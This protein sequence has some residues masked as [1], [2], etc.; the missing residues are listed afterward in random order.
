[1]TGRRFVGRV[2]GPLALALLC[3]VRVAAFP[4]SVRWGYANCATCHYNVAG[5][6]ILTPY[7]RQL[8]RELLST[9]G[10]EQTAPFAFGRV[11]TPEWLAIGG[12][13]CGY[14]ASG[15]KESSSS[16]HVM[17]AEL[18]AAVIRGRL[19]FVGTAGL[20]PSDQ[21]I[22]HGWTSSRHFAQLSLTPALSVR[23]GRFLPNY[24]IWNG[25]VSVAT[26]AGLGWD[27][28]HGSDNLELNLV[29]ERYNLGATLILGQRDRE[30]RERASGVAFTSGLFFA[31]KRK[32][33][34][35]LMATRSDVVDRQAFGLHGVIG[36]GRH[37]Y[38]LSETDLLRLHPR[39]APAEARWD[40]YGNWCLAYETIK[41]LYVLLL[42]ELARRDLA[43]EDRPSHSYGI[44]LRWFPTS[45]FE[46][47]LRLRK[48][49]E[50]AESP[51]HLN[52]LSALFRFYP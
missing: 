24:G 42:D 4:G 9:W 23:A 37:A 45:H 31:D 39:D 30:G 26:R 34:F 48:Q 5:G 21:S 27:E 17:Q 16:L 40:L 32:V 43:G 11:A 12:D 22:V 10:N 20:K 6:G 7:G 14:V 19:L 35:S 2:V 28:M 25:D 44:A 52:G 13:F 33:G 3:P 29:Q 46:I 18:E 38:L 1:M 50:R 36:I 51:P 47:Q 8:S 49:D 41:G 15:A